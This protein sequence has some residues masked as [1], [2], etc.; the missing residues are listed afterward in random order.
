MAT[1]NLFFKLAN[2][3]RIP[4]L[5]FGT[6]A[7]EK[8]DRATVGN[9]VKE[10]I[11]IGYRH[12]DCAPIYSNEAEIGKA[13]QDSFQSG[14]VKREDLFITSKLWQDGHRKEDV[15]P[16]LEKTLKDL[17]LDYLDLF[18]IHWPF[19]NK[20]IGQYPNRKAPL[21]FV[22]LSE[23]WSAMEELVDAK[24]VRSIG[25]SNFNVQIINDLLS[26]A[27]IKPQ[28]NQVELHPMLTQEGL[29]SFCRDNGILISAYAPLGGQRGGTATV[30]EQEVV[31]KI[32]HKHKKTVAQVLLRWSVQLGINPLPKSAKHERVASNFEIFEFELSPEE[33]KEISALNKNLRF[34]DPKTWGPEWLPIF[35]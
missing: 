9:L 14:L 34:N 4:A 1:K 2:G 3:N 22:P 16:A 20:N 30:Q 7:A 27:R 18:L 17:Q 11:K 31:H 32:A 15:R 25:I 26:Y 10:A 24:L 35:D 6:W 19:A 12:I 21:S 29:V 23:T 13:L 8:G 33:M 28:V 5:G